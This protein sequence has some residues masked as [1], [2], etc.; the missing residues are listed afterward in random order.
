MKRKFMAALLSVALVMSSTV[1]AFA[2][3]VEGVVAPVQDVTVEGNVTSAG[4]IVEGEH[5][6]GKVVVSDPLGRLSHALE[7]R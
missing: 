1:V 4:V 3:D 7:P 6:V 5:G 2:E